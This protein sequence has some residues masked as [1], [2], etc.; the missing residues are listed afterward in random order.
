MADLQNVV[1]TLIV[2]YNVVNW[3]N[4][5]KT[6]SFQICFSG[7]IIQIIKTNMKVRNLNVL[8]CILVEMK[9]IIQIQKMLTRAVQPALQNLGGHYNQISDTSTHFTHYN[10]T[11]YTL[12][13]LLNQILKSHINNHM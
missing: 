1:K 4:S 3:L 5:Q 8:K 2:S 13:M 10:H 6:F 9:E 12:F 11:L 7:G